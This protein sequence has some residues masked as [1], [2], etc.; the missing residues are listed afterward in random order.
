[1]A[2]AAKP[3]T[4]AGGVTG[5]AD[6]GLLSLGAEAPS[7]QGEKKIIYSLNPFDQGASRNLG[8]PMEVEPPPTGPAPGADSPS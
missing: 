6:S 8:A 2:E 1:M 7:P 4:A 3:A 5:P